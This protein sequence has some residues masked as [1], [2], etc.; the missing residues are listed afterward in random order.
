[1]LRVDGREASPGFMKARVPEDG[2]FALPLRPVSH[3]VATNAW[4]PNRM[5]GIRG[6][7]LLTSADGPTS[8]PMDWRQPVRVIV[9]RKPNETP[10]WN[11]RQ[12]YADSIWDDCL[13]D[14]NGAFV[15][16]LQPY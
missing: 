13:T 12:Y 11:S 2:S 7:V 5:V 14:T 1:P 9:A 4:T 6:R 10:A 16:A 8:R 3:W 15:A